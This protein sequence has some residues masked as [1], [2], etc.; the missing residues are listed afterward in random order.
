LEKYTRNWIYFFGNH[1]RETS[2]Y[3]INGGLKSVKIAVN[4]FSEFHS[5]SFNTRISV[6]G[7]KI[8]VIG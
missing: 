4:E 5:G 3:W 7:G 8:C 6:R 2:N 1:E